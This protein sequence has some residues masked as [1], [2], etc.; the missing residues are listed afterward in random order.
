[1]LKERKAK[2]TLLVGRVCYCGCLTSSREREGERGNGSVY[3]NI[4]F[5]LQLSN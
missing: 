1:M 4:L 3:I 5:A 2:S